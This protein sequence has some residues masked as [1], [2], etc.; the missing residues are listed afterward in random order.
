MC[1]GLFVLVVGVCV[2]CLISVLLVVSV[3][4]VLL[5]CRGWMVMVLLFYWLCRNLWWLL[6]GLIGVARCV[7]IG[8]GNGVL[9]LS[10]VCS[11]GSRKRK[12]VMWFEIGLLGS[13]R[14]I[15][16]FLCV[17]RIGLLGLIVMC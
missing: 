9:E 11:S 14:M 7:V 15:C 6:F 17:I 13:L 12:V 3:D 16:V 8:C 2:V 5:F 4:S 1:I 10:S